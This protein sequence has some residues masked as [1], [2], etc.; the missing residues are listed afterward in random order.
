LSELPNPIL[1]EPIGYKATMKDIKVI[2]E[3]PKGSAEKYAYDRKLH[4]F[5]LNKI[6][7]SGMVFPYDFGFIPKTKGQDGDPIDVLVICEHKSFPGCM[8]KCRIIGAL[9][10]EQI[11]KKRTVRNDR[12]FVVPVLSKVFKDLHSIKDISKDEM[13][14]LIN[15]FIVY[16]KI[17]NKEFKPLNVLAAEDAVKALNETRSGKH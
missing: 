8:M 14:N 13:N 10:A 17:A 15:F 4:C 12:Y 9:L 5:K 11:S 16:N 2:I 1:I 7:P 3:T 6:L